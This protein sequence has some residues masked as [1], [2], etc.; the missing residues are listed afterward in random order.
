MLPLWDVHHQ[1]IQLV[2]EWNLATQPAVLAV[3]MCELKQAFFHTF[4]FHFAGL[5]DPFRGNIDVTGGACAT[6]AAIAVYAR[7]IVLDGSVPN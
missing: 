3:V 6:A 2:G 4:R 1:S 7:D 5:F